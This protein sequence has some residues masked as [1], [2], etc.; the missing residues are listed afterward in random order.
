MT[1]NGL[2]ASIWAKDAGVSPALIYSYLTGKSGS[3]PNDIATKLA[4]AAK[5][6]VEDMF[7]R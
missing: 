1:S 2:R 6:R 5:V 7:G 3:I 4:R